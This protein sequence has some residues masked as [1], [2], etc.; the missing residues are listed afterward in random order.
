MTEPKFTVKMQA[1][2]LPLGSVFQQILAELVAEISFYC[3]SP[4]C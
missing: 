4:I 1:D 2:D 3:M